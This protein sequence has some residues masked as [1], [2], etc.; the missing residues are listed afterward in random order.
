MPSMSTRVSESSGPAARGRLSF[1]PSA[2]AASLVLT[3]A[4][5]AGP[6][7]AAVSSAVAAD[8]AAGGPWRPGAGASRLN[9]VP[10]I[11]RPE[12]DQFGE[13]PH[14]RREAFGGDHDSRGAANQADEKRRGQGPET[15]AATAVSGSLDGSYRHACRRTAGPVDG[16][17]IEGRL[18]TG[19]SPSSPPV[20]EIRDQCPDQQDHE[21]R[22]HRAGDRGEQRAFPD[23]RTPNMIPPA[24]AAVWRDYIPSL[25]GEPPALV[26]RRGEPFPEVPRRLRQA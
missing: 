6:S 23:D 11:D 5:V 12:V 9:L 15:E 10:D 22:Q 2:K 19:G 14:G 20:D 13:R 3:S 7:G 4:G 24:T 17:A 25:R 8:A 18:A 16:V 1:N 21:R 26:R